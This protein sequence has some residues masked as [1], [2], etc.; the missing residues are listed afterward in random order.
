MR[1]FTS[2]ITEP[3]EI[4]CCVSN[5]FSYESLAILDEILSSK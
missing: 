3:N 1:D 5:L 4:V 2:N